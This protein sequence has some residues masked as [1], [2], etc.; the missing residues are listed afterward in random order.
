MRATLRQY[1]WSSATRQIC[2]ATTLIPFSSHLAFRSTTLSACLRTHTRTASTL[3]V[4]NCRWLAAVGFL[5]RG[6]IMDL[7][8]LCK[9]QHFLLYFLPSFLHQ[10]LSHSCQRLAITITPT[11]DLCSWLL[12]SCRPLVLFSTHHRPLPT[13]SCL[14]NRSSTT[15]ISIATIN[16]NKI[17]NINN[18]KKQ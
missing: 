4:S 9:V 15:T 7:Q 10:P 16:N 6:P 13:P 11:P 12:S 18:N 5:I 8:Q 3:T 2:L 17:N 14:G 1:G